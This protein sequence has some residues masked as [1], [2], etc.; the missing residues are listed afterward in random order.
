M[1]VSFPGF[2]RFLLLPCAP[3]VSVL[4]GV[5]ICFFV[6]PIIGCLLRCRLRSPFPRHSGSGRQGDDLMHRG[7]SV[8]RGQT[9]RAES[10]VTDQ[11]NPMGCDQSTCVQLFCDG[12]RRRDGVF[13]LY[14]ATRATTRAYAE[15]LAPWG[16][17]Y[18]QYLV[19]IVLWSEGP[20]SV[21]KL[22][23]LLQL[24]SG[25]L[26]PLLRR[27]EGKQLIE[28][29]RDSGDQRVITVTATRHGVELRDELAHLPS[30]IAKATGLPDEFSARELIGALRRLATAISEQVGS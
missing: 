3:I 7:L 21:R 5:R 17:T 8:G 2:R 12:D 9:A 23:E 26:S 15:Q 30:V 22:G 1:S 28:R 24:D 6:F 13:S 16:L 11:G 14:S 29:T 25:I 20:Q 18:P 4:Q 27:M 19:L 10:A